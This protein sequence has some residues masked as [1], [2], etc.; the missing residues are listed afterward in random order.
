MRYHALATDYDGTLAHDGLVRPDTLDALQRFRESGR[1][2]ILVTGR[3][4]GDLKETF[5]ELDDAFD[6]V[7]AEN[8]ALLY[9]PAT[10]EEKVL[11]E[12][13][14]P[15]FVANLRRRGVS[16]LVVGRSIVATIDSEKED[17]LEAIQ[18]LGLGLQV[19]F[20]KGAVMVLPSGINKA[21]GLGHALRELAIAAENTV[22]IG[23]AEND[24]AFLGMCECSA[25]VDDAVSTLLP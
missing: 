7:V 4:L 10:K 2:L 19:I 21:T 17:V 3:R 22:A 9:N 23:D 5:S 11:S 16:P 1:K 24:H 14:S 25:A 20:N 12:A 18:E 8:G 15:D 13:P 6:L